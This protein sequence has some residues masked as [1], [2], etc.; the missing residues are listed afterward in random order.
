MSRLR[1][2]LLLIEGWSHPVC[3]FLPTLSETRLLSCLAFWSSQP[4]YSS[5]VEV[6]TH[7][8]SSTREIFYCRPPRQDQETW[9]Q[10]ACGSRS[11]RA[12]RSI[13]ESEHSRWLCLSRFQ[14]WRRPRWWRRCRRPWRS[15][16]RIA[17]S[18]ISIQSRVGRWLPGKTSLGSP[19]NRPFESVIILVSISEFD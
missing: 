2:Q 18:M 8:E 11:R 5:T 12:L 13:S 7:G 9:R 6:W 16:A 15:S 19:E 10:S 17:D 14:R 1:A 4:G 3:R